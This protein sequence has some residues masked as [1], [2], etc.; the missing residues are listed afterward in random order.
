MESK[1]SPIFLIE[2]WRDIETTN[3]LTINYMYVKI[4]SVETVLPQSRVENDR[5]KQLYDMVQ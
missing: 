1:N 2:Y 4:R 3:V 5:D